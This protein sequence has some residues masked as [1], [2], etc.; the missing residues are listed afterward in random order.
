VSHSP[1]NRGIKI[2]EITDGT[3]NTVAIVAGRDAVPW[4]RPSDLPFLPGNSLPGLDDVAGIGVLAGIADGSVRYVQGGGEDLWK[5]LI[6]PAGGEVLIWPALSHIAPREAM[7]SPSVETL[8]TPTL[9][10]QRR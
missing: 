1:G 8:P 2:E 9:A 10:C 4:I 3:S 6:I 7:R 5:K